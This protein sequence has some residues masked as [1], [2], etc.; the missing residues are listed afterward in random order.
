MLLGESAGAFTHR[1]GQI[2]TIAMSAGKGHQATKGELMD[3]LARI[4]G[5]VGGM[6][7]MVEEDRYYIARASSAPRISCR[8]SAPPS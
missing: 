4:K 3:R 1:A 7:R 8:R 5:Q 2:G 6:E